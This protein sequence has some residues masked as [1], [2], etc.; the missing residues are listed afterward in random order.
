M[1]KNDK[2]T[3]WGY[4]I[5][6]VSF[7]IYS[8]ISIGKTFYINIQLALLF[9]PLTMLVYYV[10]YKYISPKELALPRYCSLRNKA[11]YLFLLFII[12]TL[13]YVPSSE[14][15]NYTNSFNILPQKFLS[16][17]NIY[18]NYV[19]IIGA[20]LVIIPDI[21]YTSIDEKAW[22]NNTDFSSAFSKALAV[23]LFIALCAVLP[24]VVYKDILTE[25]NNIIWTALSIWVINFM[26]G[27]LFIFIK[28][29][30][31]KI[32]NNFRKTN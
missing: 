21:Q 4:K 1:N 25:K 8:L 3:N 26:W 22:K 5:A 27:F 23:F 30:T 16:N 31:L 18:F 14:I 15:E 24:V 19:I 11:S 6:F 9:I 17:H 12:I 2:V 20:F 13:N 32:F 7:I 28:F 10:G 29:I